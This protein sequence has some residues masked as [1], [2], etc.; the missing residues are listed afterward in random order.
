VY[1]I[2]FSLDKQLQWHCLS[3]PVPSTA[4]L[5]ELSARELLENA[6]FTHTPPN[7]LHINTTL[8]HL[9]APNKQTPKL[10][11]ITTQPEIIDM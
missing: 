9:C 8:A 5:N 3:I 2:F 6:N 4:V 7:K 1:S 11:Y 10:R